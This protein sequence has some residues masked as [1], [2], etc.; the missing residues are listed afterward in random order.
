MNGADYLILGVLAVSLL[1]GM[2]RGFV[3]ESIGLLA[4]LGGLWLAWRYAS[5]VEPFL[6][7]ALSEPPIRTW[8]A[9]T[10]IVVSVV[11]LGW[12]VAGIL[13]Y[14]LRH[15]SLSVV[16]DRLLGMLFGLL[17][18]A[19]VIAALVLLAQFAQMDDVKWWKRSVLMPYAVEFSTWIEAFAQ[20]GM[21]MLEEQVRLPHFSSAASSRA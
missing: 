14:L 7:G 4:W 20:T 21:R 9:R 5:L 11:L 16:V 12:L 15:S 17:R 13:G 2:Y 6:G 3:R 18:G 19:V 1:L 8:A 10:I